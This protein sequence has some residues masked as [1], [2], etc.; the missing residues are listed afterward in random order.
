[1]KH[2]VVI[3]GMGVICPLGHSVPAMWDGLMTG[4][5]GAAPTTLFDASIFPTQF[6][7]EVKGFELSRFVKN[8]DLH[9]HANRGSQFAMGACVQACRQ[10]GI[11]IET[12][13]PSDGIDRRR[14]GI[15]LGAGEGPVNFNPFFSAMIDSWDSGSNQV[16][17]PKW[18]PQALAG[19]TAENEIE[20]EPNMPVSHLA[21]LTGARGIT[22]SC[23]TACAAST[24]A[25]G[26]A[27]MLV[28]HG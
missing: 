18:T 6:D 27:M 4:K 28:R 17:W 11:E 12:N 13:N 14:M 23:L 26:E 10:A 21:R 7:A 3:T 19:L 5:S 15:Y 24:Q 16:D 22:R 20:Q 9:Q 1:M 2:R 8:A 25:V